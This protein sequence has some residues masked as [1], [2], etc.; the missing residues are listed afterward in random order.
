MNY[1]EELNEVPH[2]V[3][4]LKQAVEEGNESL[5][6]DVV[7][8]SIAPRFRSKSFRSMKAYGK[9]FRICDAEVNL[10]TCDSGVT[11]TCETLQRSGLSD[12]NL[13]SGSV[14][15]YG[16][17]KEILELD[18]GRLK[19]VLL[20]CDWVV[21]IS[22]GA[23]T[24]MKKDE[25]GFTLLKP[26]RLMRRSANSFVFPI[27]TSQ[28]FF[29]NCE[30]E[31]GWCVVLHTEPRKTRVYQDAEVRDSGPLLDSDVDLCR[32]SIKEFEEEVQGDESDDKT[33]VGWLH[34]SHEDVIMAQAAV[35]VAAQHME[36]EGSDFG[37]TSESDNLE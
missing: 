14:T 11:A 18:Y 28:I 34:V 12:V 2:F 5:S 37:S 21:P 22:R 7:D 23:T 35:K 1:P 9:Q 8:L 30:D 17:I 33:N 6:D 15:Y 29:L 24:S 31:P 3:F 20:L 16:K 25:N 19:P 27:Q 10:V 36:D 32:Q 13:I 26:R 4:W